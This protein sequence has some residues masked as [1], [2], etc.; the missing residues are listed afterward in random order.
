MMTDEKFVVV[1][2]F[3][4]DAEAEIARGWLAERGIV[5]LIEGANAATM[6]SY[7]GSGVTAVKLLVPAGAV[8][9][10][11][12]ALQEFH[13][14]SSHGQPWYCAQCCENNESAFDICWKCMRPREEVGSS[15]SPFSGQSVADFG[16]PLD[17]SASVNQYHP[18]TEPSA[19][20]QTAEAALVEQVEGDINRAWRSAVLGIAIPF[21]LSLY[22]MNLLMSSYYRSVRVSASGRQKRRL[23]WAFNFLTIAG[24]AAH[25]SYSMVWLGVV[26]CVG[27]WIGLAS[28]GQAQPA[29]QRDSVQQQNPAYRQIEDQPGLP[30]VLLIGDS[31]SIG[32]TLDVRHLLQG[33]ANVHRPPTNCG[34]TTNGLKNIERWL[35]IGGTDKKWDVIHFNWGLHDLK[36]MGPNGENLIDPDSPGSKRQVSPE[37]YEQNLRR[38][39]ER[40]KATGANLIWCNTT[41]IPKGAKGRRPGDEVAYNEIAARVM[42]EHGVEVHDLYEFARQRLGQIQKPRDVHFTDAGSRALAEQVVEIISL[43]L[44]Q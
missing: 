5:T 34:P 8:E 17:C 24:W 38:L 3:A 33:Q 37:M 15:I 29:D 43:R 32:Y 39:V 18:P 4:S 6:L 20:L 44:P 41:P 12:Q 19:D 25:L 14:A 11:E 35:A 21:L 30:R 13:A 16:Q 31:I 26:S 2:R 36:F 28:A 22:S 42:T 40:L 7:F 27:L 9:A 23:A 10:A 1:S